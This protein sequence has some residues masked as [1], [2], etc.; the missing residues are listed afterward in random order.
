MTQPREA[1]VSSGSRRTVERVRVKVV[2]DQ[3][4]M[5]CCYGQDGVAA[6]D[7]GMVGGEPRPDLDLRQRGVNICT[8]VLHRCPLA[9]TDGY[10]GVF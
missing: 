8:N 1:A 5:G 10:M 4:R 3:W 6:A 2:D 9:C 7:I